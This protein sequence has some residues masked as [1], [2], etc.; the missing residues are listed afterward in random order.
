MTDLSTRYLGMTLRSPLLASS[1]PATLGVERV[2]ELADAGV[3]AVVLPSLFEEEVTREQLRDLALTEGTEHGD[4]EAASYFPRVPS[5]GGA[6]AGAASRHLRLV[7]QCAAAVD[8]P[9]IASLNG[10]T[11]G[12]WTGF[13]RRLVDAGAAA[14]ELNVYLVP[15]DPASSGREVEDLHVEVLERVREVLEVPVA[16]KLSPYFSAT[17]EMATRLD[18]AGAHALVLFNRFLQ[19]DVDPDTLRVTTA[20]ELSSPAEARLAR[21]WVALLHRRV[22]ADLAATTGVESARDVA[23]YLLAGADVVMTASALVRHGTGHAATLLQGL[24]RWMEEHGF[25]DLTAVRGRLAVPTDVDASAH[26]RAGYVAALERARRTYGD[27]AA[28]RQPS[29]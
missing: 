24:T 26:G 9:V 6:E 29:T 2:R 21:T 17:G 12:G 4:G 11:A 28:V 19:P 14:V 7:E 16:V 20:V 1:S 27:L 18:R 23:A 13:A 8:V 10:S 15:G 22:R 3:G 5:A 25:A